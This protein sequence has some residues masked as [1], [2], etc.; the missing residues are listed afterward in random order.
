MKQ[1]WIIWIPRVLVILFIAFVMMF[2]FDIFEMKAPIWKLAVGFLIQ[3]SPAIL[4]LLVLLLTWKRPMVAGIFYGV[5]GVLVMFLLKTY[6]DAG[7]F[8]YF[9]LPLFVV[10]GLYIA[11]KYISPKQKTEHEQEPEQP[12]ETTE[13]DL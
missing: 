8:M 13:S 4:M 3:N 11:A 10:C 6:N 2:S 9:T 12:Q 5:L 7:M 1:H